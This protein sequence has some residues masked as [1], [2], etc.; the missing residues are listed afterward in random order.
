MADRIETGGADVAS[1]A[2]SAALPDGLIAEHIRDLALTSTHARA[3]KGSIRRCCSARLLIACVSQSASA[4][5][6]AIRS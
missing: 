2:P 6:R 1:I 5:S 3:R 4:R